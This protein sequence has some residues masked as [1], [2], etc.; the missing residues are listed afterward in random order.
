M[1]NGELVHG[2]V[3]TVGTY[4]VEFRQGKLIAR[5]DVH[6][7]ATEG[8]GVSADV[9]VSLDAGKVIDALEHAI[10]G[11]LDDAVLELLRKV[12]VG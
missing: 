7:E 9:E 2:N 4:D 3:G 5:V 6:H 11:Q 10:P 12:L 8:L 1:G